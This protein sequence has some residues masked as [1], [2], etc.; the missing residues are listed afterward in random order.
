MNFPHLNQDSRSTRQE[1]DF[2]VKEQSVANQP[3]RRRLNK[4]PLEEKAPEI[5]LSIPSRAQP[6]ENLPVAK[7]LTKDLIKKNSKEINVFNKKFT[8]GSIQNAGVKDHNKLGKQ[9]LQKQVDHISKKSPVFQ[10]GASKPSNSKGVSEVSSSRT[11]DVQK[12][13]LKKLQKEVATGKEIFNMK[14]SYNGKEFDVLYIGKNFYLDGADEKFHGMSAL[15]LKDGMSVVDQE[16]FGHLM[17]DDAKVKVL[18][19]EDF[20]TLKDLHNTRIENESKNNNDKG[21]KLATG[22]SSEIPREYF[23]SRNVRFGQ[24]SSK[25]TLKTELV[26]LNSFEAERAKDKKA[27]EINHKQEAIERKDE[28]RREGIRK[29]EELHTKNLEE[30]KLEKLNND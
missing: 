13:N 4:F 17:G 18:S 6:K 9:E 5:I 27:N 3:A 28:D 26:R 1:N 20:K 19:R 24:A 29:K 12:V 2:R 30:I 11:Q 21:Q 16:K 25:K 15:A 23:S 14:F 7:D 22:K 10:N 8:N